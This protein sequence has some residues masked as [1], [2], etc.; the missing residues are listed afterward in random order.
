MPEYY[1]EDFDLDEWKIFI[2]ANYILPQIQSE[3]I[4]EEERLW[5]D[6]F[7]NHLSGQMY[8]PRRYVYEEFGKY[9]QTACKDNIEDFIDIIE[10]GCGHGSTIFPLLKEAPNARFVGTDFSSKAL[11]IFRSNALFDETRVE[12]FQWD[13]CKEPTSSFRQ[14][15]DVV[16]AI[17]VLSALRSS[18]HEVA[19]QHLNSILKMG[20]IFC[21]RDYARYDMT[22]YRHQSRIGE[23][24]FRRGDGTLAYY[25]DFEEIR[26]L[27]H[28]CGFEIL[29]NYYATVK[30]INRRKKIELNR[31]FLHVVMRKINDCSSL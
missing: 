14:R 29:E 17:F 22:M 30:N 26:D 9:F 16:L 12:L 6:F 18:E 27:C 4:L 7:S 3:D 25:F 19:F 20:G 1:H 31:V 23:N 5:D 10:V 11:E 15:F 8:K 2:D 28:R 21:F 24:L 13:V